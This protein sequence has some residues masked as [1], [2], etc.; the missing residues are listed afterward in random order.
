MVGRKGHGDDAPTV[1]HVITGLGA[2]GAEAMLAKLVTASTRYRHVVVSLRDR[3]VVGARIESGGVRVEAL[4]MFGAAG[5]V[6]GLPALALLIRRTRPDIVQGWMNHGNLAA[7]LGVLLARSRAPLLWNVRQSLGGMVHEKF[8]TRRIIGLNARLSALPRMILYNSLAGAAGHEAAGFARGKRRIVPNG[9]D[10]ESFHPSPEARRLTRGELGVGEG[11]ILVGLIARLH[12]MKNHAAF[13]AAAREVSRT[14]PNLRL[15]L[16][17]DG[18]TADN[19]ELLRL[20]PDPDLLE[21]SLLLGPRGD[22]ADLTRALDIACNVSIASE[23]FAN[24][25]GEAMASAVPC[26]VT[27]V[28]DSAEIVGEGGLVCRGTDP[29]AIA[30]EMSTLV[31][32]GPKLRVR[33]GRQARLRVEAEFSL[34]AVVE[35]YERLY[36][37]A[38]GAAGSSQSRG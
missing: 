21:R 32:G 27:D 14:E 28:G 9:F 6:T 23:G 22:I 10:L 20:I 36:D 33:M 2:G 17:G 16:A 3:G 30:S 29:A 7:T 24:A 12:P 26:I 1:L 37:E 25:I 18:M 13:F 8:L 4:G 35:R 34:P 15:L 19:P 11:E 5:A 31:R 38:L